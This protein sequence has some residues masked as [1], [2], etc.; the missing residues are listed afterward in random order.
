MNVNWTKNSRRKTLSPPK[1]AWESMLCCTCWR[2]LDLILR[3]YP[4]LAPVSDWDGWAGL[5]WGE[6]VY[7]RLHLH[8]YWTLLCIHLS[9]LCANDDIDQR[10]GTQTLDKCWDCCKDF[11]PQQVCTQ[12]VKNKQTSE[13]KGCNLVCQWLRR[14][15]HHNALP[16]MVP[17]ILKEL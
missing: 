14:Y 10:W 17:M 4:T 1:A 6:D 8:T 13:C 2:A 15:D 16:Q 5:G 12:N 11:I 3:Y 9:L 7:V